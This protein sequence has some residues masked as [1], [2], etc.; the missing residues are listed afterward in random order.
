MADSIESL[1]EELDNKL[2]LSRAI[3][4][5]IKT[6]KESCLKRYL[7]LESKLMGFFDAVGYC[8]DKCPIMPVGCCQGVHYLDSIIEERVRRY[9]LPRSHIQRNVCGYHTK[10][11]YL[12]KTHKPAVCNST[13]CDG[14]R[15]YLK[16]EYG[17]NYDDGYVLVMLDLALY[18]KLSDNFINNVVK[19]PMSKKLIDIETFKLILGEW[20]AKVKG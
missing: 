3:N 16:N 11:G 1:C 6:F 17:I 2:R 15:D 8:R 10:K 12:L 9:G 7:D 20:T 19:Y 4:R 5:L 14:F 13:I 18:E